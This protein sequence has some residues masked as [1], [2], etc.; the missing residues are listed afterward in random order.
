MSKLLSKKSKRLF[1]IVFIARISFSVTIF[2][3]RFE[4]I[5]R[6]IL[7]VVACGVLF[8]SKVIF[9]VGRRNYW[10]EKV[11]YEGA[12]PTTN[13]LNNTIRK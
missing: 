11:F 2:T 5:V 9:E 7:A 4:L 12:Q 6:P 13:S 8:S 1:T 10:S 3:T